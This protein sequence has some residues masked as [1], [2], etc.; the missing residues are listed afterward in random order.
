M[1]RPRKRLKRKKKKSRGEEE[2]KEDERE[3]WR[4]AM[5]A[6]KSNC[7]TTLLNCKQL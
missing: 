2:D 5:S 6:Q 4:A 3:G 7:L 1:K